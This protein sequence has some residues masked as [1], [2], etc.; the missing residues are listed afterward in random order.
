MRR[1]ALSLLAISLGTAALTACN[2]DPETRLFRQVVPKP[3]DVALAPP[4]AEVEDSSGG[5]TVEQALE[6]CEE[7]SLRCHAQNIAGG[8]NGLTV[9]LLTVVDNV[10]QL[11][12]SHR[13]AGRR[14]WGP[15]FTVEKNG[16]FRF[17]MVRNDDGTFDWCLHAGRGNLTLAGG[18]RE[19]DCDVEEADN[20]MILVLSGELTP[21]AVAG[22]AARSGSGSMLLEGPR[23]RDLDENADDVGVITFTYDNTSG[24]DIT[25]FV[26][27]SD[28]ARGDLF[29][30]GVEYVYTSELD[31]SGTFFF[32][33][34]ANFVGGGGAF[35]F[36][37]VLED[38]EISAQWQSDGAGRAEGE[39]S[40]GDLGVDLH[41]AIQCWDTSLVTVYT[42]NTYDNVTGTGDV[43]DC[44]FEGPLAVPGSD[45]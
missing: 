13:E 35:G 3:E 29:G 25:V 6:S 21:G 23:F 22:E 10:V 33:A 15:H 17:E 8:L 40:G 24:R 38:F 34:R 27:E 2:Y 42:Q 11:P 26:D 12:P 45:S 41:S 32:G 4:G 36:D 43:M 18:M 19:L 20:G 28:G 37:P 5:N 39:I 1:T 7:D 14:V 44:A 16:T 31:G 9:G 30:A